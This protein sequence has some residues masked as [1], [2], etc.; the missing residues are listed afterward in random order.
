MSEGELKK[1]I[2]DSMILRSPEGYNIGMKPLSY[3]EVTKILDEAIKDFPKLQPIVVFPPQLAP[4]TGNITT[5]IL[6]VY[7]KRE[8]HFADM[9]QQAETN[10]IK[11]VKEVEAW[12]KKWLGEP[13]P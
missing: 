10:I 6:N 12:R 5:D 9:Q 3:P 2:S 11:Y 7:L 4:S 13:R 8:H 1:K